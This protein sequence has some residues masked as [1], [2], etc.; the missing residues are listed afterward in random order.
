MPYRIRNDEETGHDVDDPPE[1]S[2]YRSDIGFTVIFANL[3]AHRATPD[4]PRFA[5]S[6]SLDCHF[7]MYGKPSSGLISRMPNS[8]I[9]CSIAIDACWIVLYQPIVTLYR[10]GSYT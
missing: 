7:R 3:A 6:I 1:G 8:G 2:D 4:S 9:S 10:A 5:H